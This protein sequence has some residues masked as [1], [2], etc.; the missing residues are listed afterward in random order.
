MMIFVLCTTLYSIVDCVLL[1][2]YTALY[3]FCLLNVVKRLWTFLPAVV[4]T[5]VS[6][7]CYWSTTAL[8]LL[9]IFLPFSR[10]MS[11]ISQ[12]SQCLFST[13]TMTV[14]FTVH[15][16]SPGSH[17][18]RHHA[19]TVGQKVKQNFC[20]HKLHIYTYYTYTLLILWFTMVDRDSVCLWSWLMSCCYLN[21]PCKEN[22]NTSPSSPLMWHC[23]D[24]LTYEKRK[25]VWAGWELR[26]KDWTCIWK[27]H[28]DTNLACWLDTAQ[29][30]TY[31]LRGKGLKVWL[32]STWTEVL[33]PPWCPG[34]CN[35]T[36]KHVVPLKQSSHL[37][38]HLEA[39][40]QQ[41]ES[42][43]KSLFVQSFLF[44]I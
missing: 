21:S 14:L 22:K 2:C 27:C 7:D 13:Q 40:F 15:I 24:W 25:I 31:I 39:G 28:N 11:G 9:C 36:A 10:N 3:M 6:K 12:I 20:I 26:C 18:N 37:L 38:N 41:S 34:G 23:V 44:G 4:K 8:S 30:I 43:F 17:M 16:C 29:I 32:Y 5:T 19:A 35:A 33:K 1:F 42:I